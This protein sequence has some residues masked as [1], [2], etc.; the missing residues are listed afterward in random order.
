LDFS[1]AGPY[2]PGGIRSVRS[3]AFF[4]LSGGFF[5]PPHFFQFS[6]HAS[7]SFLFFPSAVGNARSPSPPP[8]VALAAFGPSVAFSSKPVSVF[9]VP[10]PALN[11]FPLEVVSSGCRAFSRGSLLNS[12]SVPAPCFPL[13]G[14]SCFEFS[15]FFLPYPSLIF[16]YLPKP[17]IFFSCLSFFF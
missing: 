16:F 17:L 9:S 11:S 14:V 5:S 7:P 13:A 6:C 12:G 15:L 2:V 10:P 3:V 4:P 8:F 1:P